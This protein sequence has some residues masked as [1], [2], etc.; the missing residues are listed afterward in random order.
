MNWAPLGPFQLI[1]CQALLETGQIPEL[2]LGAKAF[3]VH[4]GHFQRGPYQVLL[5]GGQVQALQLRVKISCILQGPLQGTIYQGPDG[6]HTS[7]RS[8]LRS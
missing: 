6:E 8:S 3:M 5:E 2:Q 7:S 4:Q 1:P